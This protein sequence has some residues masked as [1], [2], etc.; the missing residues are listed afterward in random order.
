[1]FSTKF[2][3]AI[4]CFVFFIPVSY[5]SHAQTNL[6][7]LTLTTEKGINLLS[8]YCQ[9]D[10]IKSI[11]VQRSSDSIFNY[12]TIGYVKNLAKGN[13][14]YIDGHPVPGNNFYRLYIVFSSDI[15]WMSNRVRIFIDSAMLMQKTVLPPNDSLQKMVKDVVK[16]SNVVKPTPPDPSKINTFTYVRSQF[17]FTNPFTGHINIELP[18]TFNIQDSYRLKFFDSKSH[19]IMDIPHL[20]ER[21]IILDK[22][23]FQKK[24][25][26]K[27]ELYKNGSLLESGYVTIY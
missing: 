22:R 18:E 16:D 1:M 9:Y 14:G 11:A 20:S 15:T 5:V 4:F 19:K 8:W 27:F 21:E 12:A 3:R 25:M 10:G 23:N 13:Q 6:P 7:D 17:V 24:G 2:L 26:F